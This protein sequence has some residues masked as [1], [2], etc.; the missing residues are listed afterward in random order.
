MRARIVA[1]LTYPV[2]LAVA[3]TVSIAVIA[4]LVVPR[5][6]ELLADQQRTLP[7]TT[8]ML[9]FVSSSA[10][11]L[12]H[13]A[14]AVAVV[15]GLALARWARTP[16]G[17]KYV[18]RLLLDL[19]LI[20]AVRL[21][22]ASART[23]G[24]LAGLLEAGVPLLAA[25]DHAADACGD[26]AIRDRISGARLDVERGERLAHALRRHHVMT[27]Q[28]LRLVGF[29][30]TT[31]R[32]TVFFRHAARLDAAAAHRSMQRAI[33][34]L[35]PMLILAFGAAVAFVAAALLQAVYSIRPAAF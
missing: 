11:S 14:L 26:R 20:G 18:H 6:A 29:G 15:A 25:L 13:P 35:E 19:P 16:A 5:F 9:L 17:T 33:M 22:F 32:L 28:A 4:G 34:L 27:D 21:R 23:C 31:G 7:A 3:G 24:A 1:A 2:F 12:A 8:R 10:V 30:E